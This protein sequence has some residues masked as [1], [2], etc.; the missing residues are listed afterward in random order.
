MLENIVSTVRS[1]RCV[2]KCFWFPSRNVHCHVLVHK[3]N[4]LKSINFHQRGEVLIHVCYM[5][6]LG[7]IYIKV[8][9]L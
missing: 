6:H 1:D 9:Y 3:Y 7:G 4:F 2:Q 8:E 5:G